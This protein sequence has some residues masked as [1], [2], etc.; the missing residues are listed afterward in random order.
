[1]N[2]SRSSFNAFFSAIFLLLTWSVIA[3]GQY[4]R[5]TDRGFQPSGS[6]AV[7]D[8]ETINTTNGNV[9][10]NI[11]LAGL[12]AGRGGISAKVNLVYDSKLYNTQTTYS[13]CPAVPAGAGLLPRTPPYP[14]CGG[15]PGFPSELLGF[16]TEGGWRYNFKY[17][18][19]V[20]GSAYDGHVSCNPQQPTVV[21]MYKMQV[22]YPDGSAHDFRLS[23]YSEP[24]PMQPNYFPIDHGGNATANSYCQGY[25]STTNN[26][27]YYS[28]DGTYSRLEVEHGTLAW[29]LYL[30]DGSR[31]TSPTSSQ[32]QRI[33]DRNNNYI[34]IVTTG[35]TYNGNP[36]TKIFDQL[37][38]QVIIENI[39]ATNTDLI[40]AWGVGNQELIWTVKWKTISINKSYNTGWGGVM[41]IPSFQKNRRVVDQI[42][43]PAIAGQTAQAY[44]F[45]YNAGTANPSL[46]WGE[47]SSIT[48]PT[49]AQ[50]SYIWAMD[51][52]N[53]GN[54]IA[55]M[56]FKN[57]LVR[58]DLSYLAEFDG[59]SSTVTDQWFY[60]V[61][62]DSGVTQ[63]TGPN[64]AVTTE[65][66]L[67]GETKGFKT[68]R[69]D[70]SI[71]ERIWANNNPYG[72]PHGDANNIVK[73][74]FT[75]IRDAA[76]TLSKTAI[77]D[78][79]YDKNGNV[80]QTTEYDWVDWNTVPRDG[81]GKP[82]GIP[83]GAFINRV[84]ANGYYN[85]TADSANTTTNDP[86]AYTYLTAPRMLRALSSTEI[87]W[88][89]ATDGS[90][91]LSRSEFTYDN[92]NTTGN[93]TQQKSWDS[94]KGGYSNPLGANSISV[95][96]QYNSYGSPTLTT[97][98]RGY[99]TQL[100][101]GSV[102]GFTDLYPTQMK[103]A[104]LSSVQRTETRVR[105]LHWGRYPG[106][107]C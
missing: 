31:V 65:H 13:N 95:S 92:A 101:Y 79:K 73:T 8:F 69:P 5:T 49:G 77:V 75:S 41:S 9:M 80:T 3:Q 15:D 45:G 102:G 28:I 90:Q 44:T 63:I 60:S 39:A 42:I 11:P 58:K 14:G 53:G 54:V 86:N 51:G 89:N 105:F 27:V 87:K 35:F 91:T 37:G 21:D 23:G 6:Y 84:S 81:S 43:L 22:I 20:V 68:E 30:P 76:G 71:V 33:Y 67:P 50:V 94:T 104:Y 38:R 16:S 83:G 62:Q 72:Y 107:R 66:F 2:T 29:T 74:E 26:L 64:S 55:D 48:T 46:G 1:M 34:E 10:L 47:V 24:D 106:Y 59:S 12:P 36:A 98:A 40:R 96:T 52:L 25:S 19:R 93:L 70:G 56:V 78:Y 7:G 88:G 4:T 61:N 57:S 103:T 99:Q 85:Q 97:D 82:T 32:G 17:A 100:Y 18:L